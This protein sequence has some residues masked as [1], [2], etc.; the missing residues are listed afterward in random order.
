MGEILLLQEHRGAG[1][2]LGS[3]PH[4]PSDRGAGG[5]AGGGLQEQEGTVGAQSPASEQPSHRITAHA[6]TGWFSLH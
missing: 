5:G 6:Q 3:S 2:L 1:D 4:L